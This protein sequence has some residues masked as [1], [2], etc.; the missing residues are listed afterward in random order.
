MI[1]TI[2]HV[3][4]GVADLDR[5]VA[6]YRDQLGFKCAYDFASAKGEKIGQCLYVGGQTFIELFRGSAPPPPEGEGHR[7]FCLLVDD[8]EAA[9]ADLL[10]RGVEVTPVSTGTDRSRNA[11]FNDPDGHRL[12]LQQYTPESKQ[13]A[14]VK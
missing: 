6:F 12:E 2:A 10:R 14:W 3:C 7:H 9:R 11:W 13:G 4:L 1:K 5:A 8:I